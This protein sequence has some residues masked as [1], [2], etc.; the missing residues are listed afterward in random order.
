MESKENVDEIRDPSLPTSF[1]PMEATARDI[2]KCF[3]MFLSREQLGRDNKWFCKKCREHVMGWKK[4]D[5]WWLPTHL[6]IAIKRFDNNGRRKY[7]NP[8]HYP[9][10]GLDLSDI[11]RGGDSLDIYRSQR[12]GG[13]DAAGAASE[14]KKAEGKKERFL[15]DL[16]A[17]INHSGS[18]NFGHYTANVKYGKQWYSISDSSVTKC[19]SDPVQASAYI[20]CYKQR[21]TG[22]L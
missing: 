19:Y 9:V 21:Q 13:G 2:R 7:S 12:G 6:V 17:V 10:N 15:Y 3:G 14:H 22:T 5:L 1:Q 16:Y 18:L 4:L 8:V 11:I 20:L